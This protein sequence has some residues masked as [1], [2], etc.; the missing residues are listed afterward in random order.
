M[1]SGPLTHD[2][3]A[4]ATAIA[5]GSVEDERDKKSAGRAAPARVQPVEVL[6]D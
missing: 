1:N 5:I 2:W 6:D 4:E 3:D